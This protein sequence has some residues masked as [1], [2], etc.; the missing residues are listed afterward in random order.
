MRI[1]VTGAAG[2]IGSHIFNTLSKMEEHEVV[3]IDDLSGGYRENVNQKNDLMIFDLCDTKKTNIAMAAVKPEVVIH[4][5]ASA[6]EIG[7][8]SSPLNQQRQTYMPTLI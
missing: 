4:C 3:G 5:A 8:Y 2:F 7:S 1:I 6:R